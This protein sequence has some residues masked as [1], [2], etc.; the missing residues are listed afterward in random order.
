MKKI[1]WMLC[2]T[3]VLLFTATAMAQTKAV[4]I[5]LT[6]KGAI[7]PTGPTGPAGPDGATGPIGPTGAPGPT[8]ATGSDGIAGPTGP[9]G[10]RGMTGST[11][12]NGPTGAQGPT[13]PAG[14]SPDQVCPAPAYMVGIDASGNIVCHDPS[15]KVVFVT[16]ATY[17]GNLGGLTGA[18]AK[19]QALADAAGIYG[20]FKAWLSDDTTSPKNSAEFV[21]STV[22]YMTTV[23]TKIANDFTD[24]TDGMLDAHVY[25]DENGQQVTTNAQAW[26]NTDSGGLVYTTTTS[27]ICNNW[28]DAGASVNGLV[29][30][31]TTLISNWTEYIFATCDSAARL[32]CIEQ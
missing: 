3:A 31:I 30:D 12:P 1:F 9:T 21:K 22:P 16:S 32:Y 11:G 15:F 7:G 6:S 17:N 14:V 19:C 27:F 28:T 5:P 23:G 8:G 10:P 24:I 26:T 13:G 18:D 4:I 20:I 29:G 25:Y 2:A